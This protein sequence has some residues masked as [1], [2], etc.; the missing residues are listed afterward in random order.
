MSRS[1]FFVCLCHLFTTIVM[2]QSQHMICKNVD[3]VFD[4]NDSISS[5]EST[6]SRS[7]QGPPGKRG[8]KGEMG[9]LGMPGVKGQQGDSGNVDY[10]KVNATVEQLFEKL[11]EKSV[12]SRIEELEERMLAKHDEL[13]K[14]IWLG[15]GDGVVHLGKCYIASLHTARDVNYDEAVA[16]CTK[17]SAKP[18]DIIGSQHYDMVMY[19]DV[20]IIRRSLVG[21]DIRPLGM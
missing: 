1:L 10:Q 14:K 8:L 21:H 6:H 13:N 9:G 7:F 11:V 17:L 15:P 20:F 2:S 16:M 3:D 5:R 19:N 18:A 4:E 12:A